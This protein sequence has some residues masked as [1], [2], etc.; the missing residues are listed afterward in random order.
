MI[1]SPVTPNF[2]W[3]RIWSKMAFLWFRSLLIPLVQSLLLFSQ[4][5]FELLF[6]SMYNICKYCDRRAEGVDNDFQHLFS[7]RDSVWLPKRTNLKEIKN[8][9][10]VNNF[11]QF[12]SLLSI[13]TSYILFGLFYKYNF[14][15]FFNETKEDM[16]FSILLVLANNFCLVA[17]SFCLH[18]TNFMFAFHD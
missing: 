16:W 12:V 6:L 10:V 2:L 11:I 17:D 18:N 13:H 7:W 14:F 9:F 15:F 3:T 4:L 1:S 5:T 8:I